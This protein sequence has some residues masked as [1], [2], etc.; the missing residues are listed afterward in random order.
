MSNAFDSHCCLTPTLLEKVKQFCMWQAIPDKVHAV[1]W[2]SF[3]T[4]DGQERKV[5]VYRRLK[6]G[7]L[8]SVLLVHTDVIE[9][10]M[11]QDRQQVTLKV[12]E[13][14]EPLVQEIKDCKTA[15]LQMMH[16]AAP[17]ALRKKKNKRV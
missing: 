5:P 15:I 12:K 8:E 2:V 1:A 16:M 9:Y 6:P 13:E 17:L 4:E 3:A 14:F 10:V 7:T 11:A